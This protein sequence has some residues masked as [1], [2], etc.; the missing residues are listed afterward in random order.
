M[1]SVY[2]MMFYEAQI[3]LVGYRRGTV[4]SNWPAPLRLDHDLDAGLAVGH[5]RHVS[6]R[7]RSDQSARDR[8]AHH[9]GWWSDRLHL[10]PHLVGWAIAEC[11]PT[12]PFLA[13]AILWV[14]TIVGYLIG[15][16]SAGR[17]LEKV[18]L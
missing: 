17:E 10:W 18:Q 6:Q 15:P 12:I 2:T 8:F 13:T 7:I 3:L 9:G 14:K 4:G 11:E 1:R 16:E 5:R